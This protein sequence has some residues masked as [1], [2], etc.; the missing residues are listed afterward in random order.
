VVVNFY[1]LTQSPLE[2]VLPSICERLLA[3]GTRILIVA[4]EILLGR[5]DEQLWT[6]SKESFLPHGRTRAQSQPV[7]LS[8]EAE[9]TNGAAA[10][11]MGD[12]AWR[13]EA[14][15]FER[16]YFFFDSADLEGARSAW[17]G[18][19]GREGVE[20][21]YWKQDENGKWVQGP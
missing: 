4:D 14:L 16:V 6:Y 10:I 2:R 3:A 18:L 7:L 17:R 5:L 20:P 12:G 11:M 8:T 21:R 1:H 9:P 19:R 15:A 13:E